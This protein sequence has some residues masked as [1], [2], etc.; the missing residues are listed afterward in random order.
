MTNMCS[1]TLVKIKKTPSSP[2]SKKINNKGEENDKPDSLHFVK[3]KD[4]PAFP[5]Q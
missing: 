2:F 4:K 3:N 1:K 5:L